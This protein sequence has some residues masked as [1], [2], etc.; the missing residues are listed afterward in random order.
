LTF[1]HQ[2]PAIQQETVHSPSRRPHAGCQANWSHILYTLPNL[3]SEIN[4]KICR[5]YSKLEMLIMIRSHL[6]FTMS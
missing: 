4:Q 2:L 1:S 5:K 6:S 3:I